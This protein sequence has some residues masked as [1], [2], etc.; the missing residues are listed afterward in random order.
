[1][2]LTHAGTPPPKFPDSDP[3]D[4]L[5]HLPQLKEKVTRKSATV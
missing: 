1:M 2:S 3:L 4:Q 5:E